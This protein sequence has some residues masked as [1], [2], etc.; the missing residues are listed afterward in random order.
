MSSFKWKV[1]IGAV[2]VLNVLAII[3]FSRSQQ[4]VS[5]A[6]CPRCTPCLCPR[7]TVSFLSIPPVAPSLES[8]VRDCL[9]LGSQQ[10]CQRTFPDVPTVN[11][12]TMTE[13]DSIPISRRTNMPDIPITFVTVPR[14]FTSD[15]NVAARQRASILSWHMLPSPHKE[16]LLMGNEKGVAELAEEFSFPYVRDLALSPDDGVPLMD[17]IMQLASEKA[18]NG[19][20]CFINSDISLPPSWWQTVQAALPFLLAQPRPFL[21]A[22]PRLVI[23]ESALWHPTVTPWPQFRAQWIDTHKYSTP[24]ID[25]AIDWFVFRRFSYV[26]FPPFKLGRYVWDSYMVDYAV[27]QQWT[28][29]VTYTVDA[30][31]QPA[32]GLHWDHS[33]AHQQDKKLGDDRRGNW[34]VALAAGAGSLV[35]YGRLRGMELGLVP[36]DKGEYCVKRRFDYEVLKNRLP[37]KKS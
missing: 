18:S 12:A 11:I 6:I 19:V 20:I 24:I 7:P 30:V 25:G 16:V 13:E 2:V 31:T 28:T 3:V 34:N 26:P 37:P 8:H 15:P 10:A 14:D 32:Y 21:L 4:K 29:L 1:G 22:G 5:A 9:S 23:P 35:E 33:R 27:R 17:S 36:C